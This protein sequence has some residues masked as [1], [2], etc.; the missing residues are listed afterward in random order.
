MTGVGDFRGKRV[1]VTGAGGFLGKRLVERLLGSG[2]EVVALGRASGFDLLE[3]EIPLSATDH[4]FHLAAETGVP[5]SWE[6]PVRFHLVNAHGTVRVLDQCRKAGCSITYVGAYI[7]GIPQTLPISEDHPL[8]PN[9]PYAFSKWMGEQACEWYA[10]T[11][12]LAVTAVRLFNVYG[13]GQS[14]RF[15]V[16]SLVAQALDPQV[17]SIKLMDMSPK[18][19]YLYIEDAVDALLAS[20]SPGGYRLYNVGSGVS[21]SVREVVNVV[22]QAVGSAKPIVEAG[23]SR[24]NEIPDV[25][26]DCSRISTECGW[27]PRYTLAAGVGQ[28]VKEALN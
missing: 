1:V 20:R 8:D 28:M 9:N 23:E 2:C 11:Y 16:A 6:D 4:V 19:D 12:G 15:L 26:A 27:V 5:A 3:D 13:L 22:L 7:Y 25:R 21:H 18:R 17:L 14:D 24:R 10:G